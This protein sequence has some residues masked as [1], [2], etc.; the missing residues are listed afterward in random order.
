MAQNGE[1]W[2]T[3]DAD[4]PTGVC[5]TWASCA[6]CSGS[7]GTWD[8]H[9]CGAAPSC[10][11]ELVDV[12]QAV[13]GA[14]C[15]SQTKQCK[16]VADSQCA[17]G[18]CLPWTGCATGACTGNGTANAFGCQDPPKIP[19]ACTAS[20]FACAAPAV[21]DPTHAY[22]WCTDDSQC[23]SGLCVDW[24]GCTGNCTGP[25]GTL[26]SAHCV[27][28]NITDCKTDNDCGSTSTRVE[29]CSGSAGLGQ[30]TKSC[31]SNSQC[32]GH[33]ICTGS[34]GNPGVCK[35]CSSNANCYDR[36]YPATC[37]GALGAHLGNCCG[38]GTPSPSIPNT[39]CG[40][41]NALFPQG[42]LNA[43]MSDQEK[44]LEFMFFDLTACVT[45]D[46]GNPSPPKP[47][48]DPQTFALDFKAVCASGTLPKW[49]EFDYQAAFPSPVSGSS[50]TFEA[51][52]GP[53]GGAPAD[54]LPAGRLA[55]TTT[56]TNTSLPAYDAVLL[57]T[58]PG[59]SGKF[60]TANPPVSSDFVLRIWVTMTPTT[61]QYTSPTLLNWKVVYDCPPTL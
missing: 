5:E 12:C 20:T 29:F 9:H 36:T 60:V 17:T 23:P 19:T 34:L 15:D 53:I 52:T 39:T 47:K 44:A 6:D 38:A 28:A 7:S 24:T 42:C 46:E 58:S 14:G 21:C 4:C 56:N 41:T 3:R 25:S 1:C 26:D 57:D 37:D 61:D 10:S 2:C 59:G 49:R 33:E 31:T 43:P 48:L 30:C 40:R 11:T 45:P 55:L 16:C 50:I 35:G 51:Q 8:N 13:P 54:F 18:K 22:C 32:P 27:P